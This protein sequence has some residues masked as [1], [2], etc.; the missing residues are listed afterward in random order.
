[1][2]RIREFYARS[3]L[4]PPELRTLVLKNSEGLLL[5]QTIVHDQFVAY[6]RRNQT[7]RP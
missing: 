5:N 2:P 3:L 6:N 7:Q 4:V 1:M